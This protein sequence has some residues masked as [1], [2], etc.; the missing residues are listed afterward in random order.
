MQ[1]IE[2]YQLEGPNQL[3]LKRNIIDKNGQG[4][5]LRLLARKLQRVHFE[6]PQKHS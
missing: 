6:A 2:P 3:S 5:L 4:K 1:R